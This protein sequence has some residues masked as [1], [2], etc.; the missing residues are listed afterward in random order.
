MN[1][2][3]QNETK[4]T[5]FP[6]ITPEEDN[7]SISGLFSR[8]FKGNKAQD[9]TKQS[10]QATVGPE[11]TA[12]AYNAG[13]EWQAEATKESKEI[14]NEL[15][16]NMKEG[17]SLPNLRRR[18]S[19]LLRS[20]RQSYNDTELK[21]YWMPDSVSKECY[22][23]GER[24]TTFRR[25]HHCRVCGLIFCSRCCFQ[26]IPGKIMNCTG[27]L[28]VCTH[29]GHLVL[30][31]LRS[32]EADLNTD[33]MAL[34]DDL[35]AKFGET[36]DSDQLCWDSVGTLRNI[37]GTGTVGSA[38][39]S[40]SSSVVADDGPRRKTSLGYYEESIT[41]VRC[42]SGRNSMRCILDEALSSGSLVCSTHRYRLR[43]YHSCFTAAELID[44]LVSNYKAANRLQGVVLGQAM[45]QYGYIECITQDSNQFFDN[46]ALYR[47]IPGDV[48][49][50][51]SRRD[52]SA[53]S[54]TEIGLERTLKTS[55]SIFNLDV[56]IDDKSVFA[57]RPPACLE[58]SVGNSACER[59]SS[60]ERENITIVEELG[61][62]VRTV[63]DAFF[64]NNET[65]PM[66]DYNNIHP[67]QLNDD[68]RIPYRILSEAFAEHCSNY[69]SQLFE[70][71]AVSQSWADFI[72][73][74]TTRVVSS[75]K[76][77]LA[78][79]N[80]DVMDIRRY[81]Q[82]KKVAGGL[83]RECQIVAGVV[84]S[85]NLPRKS[86]PTRM[87]DPQILLLSSAV[88][89]QRVEGKYLSLEPVI[90]QEQDYVTRTVSKIV[91][92][93]ANIVIVGKSVVRPAQDL[94][95]AK[96]I[97]F[98]ANVKSSVL[99]RLARLTGADILSSVDAHLGSPK[100]GVCSLFRVA[101]FTNDYGKEKTLMIFEGCRYPELGCTILLRGGTNCELARVKKVTSNL[102]FAKYNAQL[103]ISYLMDAGAQPP[104]PPSSGEGIFSEIPI[105]VTSE[106]SASYLNSEINGENENLWSKDKSSAK[107]NVDKNISKNSGV[108]ISFIS[109]SQHKFNSPEK[110]NQ[111]RSNI[112]EVSDPE[113]LTHLSTNCTT[114]S[115]AEC[116]DPLR[117]YSVDEVQ[118]NGDRNFSQGDSELSVS[119]TTLPLD[120]RFVQ[121]LRHNIL[122]VSA[123]LKFTLPYL[124]SEHGRQCPLRSYF[125]QKI[126][127]SQFLD[128]GTIKSRPIREGEQY[129]LLDRKP[130]IVKLKPLHKFVTARLTQSA[131]SV[132]VQTLLASFR[133]GGGRLPIS[134]SSYIP[135]PPLP[136]P[137]T[138]GLKDIL[139]PINHQ[140]LAL[141][142][143]MYSPLSS[144][145]PGFCV[146][147]RIVTIELYNTQD[148]PLGQ[149][150][151][152]YC[153]SPKQTCYQGSC[154][155][156][157]RGHIRRFVHHNGVVH[158]K[159]QNISKSFP[160]Y[161]IYTLNWCH[162]C[163][164][165]TPV[166]RLSPG[167]KALSFAKYL[168]LRFHGD[169]YRARSDEKCD[170]L[171]QNEYVHYFAMGNM[172]ASFTYSKISI[173]EISLPP[174]VLK[175]ERDTYNENVK[176]EE[177]KTWS[178]MGAQV[179]SAIANKIAT[180]NI[181]EAT[182]SSMRQ[183]LHKDQTLF[184]TRLEEVQALLGLGISVS[185]CKELDNDSCGPVT[186]NVGNVRHQWCVEDSI[187]MV[188]RQMCELVEEWNNRLNEAEIAAKKEEKSKKTNIIGENKQS[189]HHATVQQHSS[190]SDTVVDGLPATSQEEVEPA[191]LG[192]EAMDQEDTSALP[193]RSESLDT[194]TGPTDM[195]DGDGCQAGITVEVKQQSTTNDKKSVK[196][197]L[198]QLLPSSSHNQHI[199]IPMGNLEHHLLPLGYLVPVI[200]YEKEPSSIIA[201]ALNCVE[202]KAALDQIR[203]SVGSSFT[204]NISASTDQSA[205]NS[206]A[207]K[208]RSTPLDLGNKDLSEVTVGSSGGTVS[209]N[210]KTS[211][212]SV[213][214]FLRT[215]SSGSVDKNSKGGIEGVHYT[216]SSSSDAFGEEDLKTESEMKTRSP[217]PQS[218][219]I[220]VEFSDSG[221][222]FKVKV[223]YADDFSKLRAL[224]LPEEEEGYIRSLSRCVAW[225]ASG[226]K[227]G[228]NFNKTKDDRFILKEMTRL[229]TQLFMTFAPQY[230]T[231]IDTCVRTGSPT[232]LG[233]ILGVYRVI[234]RSD[235]SNTTLRSSL[236]VMEHLF[237][238]RLVKN[239]F[240]LKGSMRNRLVDASSKEALSDTVLLDENLINMTC[241]NPLYI[242][243]HSK[244]ILM[245]AIHNDTL[246]LST[247]YVMDYSLLVGLDQTKKELVVGIIDYIR[248]FTWDKKLETM[249]KSI[250]QNKQPTVISPD[251]YRERFIAAMHR[252]FLPVPDRWT[253]FG[254]GIDLYTSSWT[255]EDEEVK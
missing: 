164:V 92:L 28:K 161:D 241:D 76:P 30:T 145:F 102:L 94:L 204:G 6:P 46:G 151:E 54:E 23:C 251:E 2:N 193:R 187:V 69:M 96:G 224:V 236:L 116:N 154:D 202:Y 235:R 240:D 209:D 124:E 71:E 58:S 253:G 42:E 230:F 138:S 55:N 91:D 245:Q 153:F 34:L 106:T 3:L 57:S 180:L 82:I 73:P 87:I 99:E 88:M 248:T 70:R 16:L 11:E 168:E 66:V 67:S 246:F 191:Q 14:E 205:K 36:A 255:D 172:L 195:D 49:R 40:I 150:L 117:A 131:D 17:R 22:N 142:F 120:N 212:T 51:E 5:E 239:K 15:P 113:V 208:R 64:S 141:L 174:L 122:S 228:S 149:F 27:D 105:T 176:I 18:I 24:F 19:N 233:K 163:N 77:Y 159:L 254:K 81:V 186:G 48:V 111:L 178:L 129:N 227:S 62:E 52:S 226:G 137:D 220:E 61:N 121:A 25:R 59:G 197:I 215:S 158:V 247:Q 156:P 155:T 126:Y 140:R 29:C 133:A 7:S 84:C 162:Q 219:N 31:Y 188:K 75:I 53:D 170:H 213:L 229:E 152:R 4:L 107:F 35:E 231:Y 147:P 50:E 20:G 225:A 242:L 171:L 165:G 214:S 190:F 85:K 74:L 200:V 210:K 130:D 181:G 250:G 143:C 68:Q 95:A 194:E 223:Y 134:H 45:L 135:L 12:D 44:W 60:T 234:C 169:M 218:Q 114:E 38:G 80:K 83:K 249:V 118:D 216:P 185:A 243:P 217:K 63:I 86:M 232:L 238:A 139:D 33:Q 166:R 127:W 183:Q 199:Q 148:I 184:K 222:N 173:W 21:Q 252:Y 93:G 79:N 72:S 206:P 78:R 157:A 98:V 97:S 43:T 136:F 132:Q 192:E 175:T 237:H 167:A 160:L 128:E 65:L 8:F 104:C 109:F 196:A 119:E 101:T 10:G 39:V 32:S 221:A 89:Y 189:P 198:A 103:E 41:S 244:T 115:V 1:R 90:M 211:G 207:A 9:A 203:T 146:D 100:L 201:Y 108:E 112:S 110:S 56:N 123:Y 47:I 177:M 37:A 179:F 144:N 125:G 26:E 182:V 13:K